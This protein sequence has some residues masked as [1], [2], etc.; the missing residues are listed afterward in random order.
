MAAGTSQGTRRVGYG[1]AIGFNVL[2]LVVAN[3]TFSLEIAPWLTDEFQ[4]VLLIVNFWLGLGIFM[5]L[6]YMAYDEV[7]FKAATQAV[8]NIVSVAVIWRLLE[9]FPFDFSEYNFNWD[10]VVRG[11]LWLGL[12]GASIGVVVE[13]VRLA[14]GPKSEPTA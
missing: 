5:N 12:V 3:N 7:R 1:F 11:V 8:L 9:V 13:V 14:R 4:E 10:L 2:F 6:V